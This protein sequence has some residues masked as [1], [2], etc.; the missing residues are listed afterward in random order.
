MYHKGPNFLV[1]VLCEVRQSHSIFLGKHQSFPCRNNNLIKQGVEVDAPLLCLPQQHLIRCEIPLERRKLSVTVL[2]KRE[3]ITNPVMRVQVDVQ[4][5]LTSGAYTASRASTAAPTRRR[6]IA[7]F[8][9]LIVPPSPGTMETLATSSVSC[10]DNA[11]GKQ[12]ESVYFRSGRYR[13]QRTHNWGQLVGSQI[14]SCRTAAEWREMERY[15]GSCFS[16]PAFWLT[17]NL[18]N[19][20]SRLICK[21]TETRTK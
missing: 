18:E 11:F 2:Q 13:R 4:Q 15:V 8:M 6:R 19:L 17:V 3:I 1:K 12:A 5:P 7:A 20:V 16:L 21:Y 10:S 14:I 9:R